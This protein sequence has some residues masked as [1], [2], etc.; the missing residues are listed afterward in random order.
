EPVPRGDLPGLQFRTG[1]AV[2][3]GGTQGCLS[4]G[5][6]DLARLLLHGWNDPPRE[7]A[8]GA[9]PDAGIVGQIRAALRQR[10]SRRRRQP[11]PTYSL[12]CKQAGR[13]RTRRAIRLRYPAVVRRGWRRIDGRTWSRGRKTRFD[14]DHVFGNRSQPAAA[15]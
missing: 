9:A 2:V 12:R 5:G 10:V 6:P 1:A 11:A 15:A 14:A 4:G 8:V 7:T 3:L 13:A